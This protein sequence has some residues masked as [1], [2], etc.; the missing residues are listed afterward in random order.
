MSL[1]TGAYAL[2]VTRLLSLTSLS[3]D[4]V[5]RVTTLNVLTIE[6]RLRE[7]NLTTP[8]L[9][10]EMEEDLEGEWGMAGRVSV[11]PISIGY[12][13]SVDVTDSMD[14]IETMLE[15]IKLGLY[16]Y[17]A[18]SGSDVLQILKMPT[19]NADFTNKFNEACMHLQNGL[20]AGAVRCEAI[21]GDY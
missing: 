17:Q 8:F 13:V 21:Y 20:V 2:L 15:T 3:A 4:D 10:L 11:T 5:V 16:A 7:A 14:S 19:K 9:I 18:T 12:V 6:E 1:A